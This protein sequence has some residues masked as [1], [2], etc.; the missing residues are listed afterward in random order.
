[1]EGQVALGA[2][3]SWLRYLRLKNIR[4]KA[5]VAPRRREPSRLDSVV[6]PH[7]VLLLRQW[8]G[9]PS[10][11]AD[12]YGKKRGQVYPLGGRAPEPSCI[13][14]EVAKLMRKVRPMAFWVSCF[15]R[16]PP[17][18]WEPW[19]VLPRDNLPEL[20][21]LKALNAMVWRELG[22]GGQP[23]MQ[24]IP[25]V[26]AW[27]PEKPFETSL[28]VECKGEKDKPKE[29]QED[30]VSGAVAHGV[31]AESFAVAIRRFR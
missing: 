24:G 1:M 29:T 5:F 23:K 9:Q 12:D 4:M 27:D 7:G 22:F 10:Q 6:V 20:G 25:D 8:K 21:W 26:V 31:P 17:P 16:T 11:W 30:W 19:V 3:T 18:R 15:N 14:I 28:F 13:E 2:S